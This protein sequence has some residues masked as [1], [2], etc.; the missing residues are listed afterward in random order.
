MILLEEQHGLSEK[1]ADYLS[2]IKK[3]KNHSF[4]TTALCYYFNEQI[5][6]AQFF[7]RHKILYG[8]L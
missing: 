8:I 2:R 3:K 5:E 1:A 7:Y 4:S 6:R